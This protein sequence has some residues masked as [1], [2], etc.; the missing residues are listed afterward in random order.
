M[1]DERSFLTPDFVAITW[2]KFQTD[3]L[4]SKITLLIGSIKK[5]IAS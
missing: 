2:L 5:L 1:N 3:L 4:N